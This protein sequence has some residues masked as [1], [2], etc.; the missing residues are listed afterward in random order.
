MLESTIAAWTAPA[1]SLRKGVVFWVLPASGTLAAA[2]LG[3]GLPEQESSEI[4]YMRAVSIRYQAIH[5]SAL[6]RDCARD[7]CSPEEHRLH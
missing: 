3:S 5:L 4:L 1:H 2:S 7:S 6:M